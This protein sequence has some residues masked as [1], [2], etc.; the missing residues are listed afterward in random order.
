MQRKDQPNGEPLTQIITVELPEAFVNPMW[1]GSEGSYSWESVSSDGGIRSIKKINSLFYNPFFEH[2]RIR[3]FQRGD[4][5]SQD[6]Y[7]WET[8][9]IMDGVTINPNINIRAGKRIVT[10][11][12]NRINPYVNMEIT[13]YFEGCPGNVLTHKA[14]D[15]EIG[16]VCSSVK[17]KQNALFKTEDVSAEN[18]ESVDEFLVY[19]NP[20][21]EEFFITYA[22]DREQEVL[23]EIYDVTGK[24]VWSPLH[25]RQPAGIRKVIVNNHQLSQGVYF[26]KVYKEKQ[27]SQEK[28][29]ILNR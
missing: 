21:K 13:G 24:M 7:A 1:F 3:I 2:P 16:N 10:D 5:I 28:I 22:L 8:V 14:T 18:K 29:V 4:V 15:T 19:P 6:V 23:I 26:I 20:A 11:N 25:S 17:Y 27:V 12:S 9:K